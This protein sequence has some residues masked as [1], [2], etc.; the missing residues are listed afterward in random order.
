MDCRTCGQEVDQVL[1]ACRRC[2]TPAGQPAVRPDVPVYDLVGV[3]RLAT[4]AVVVATASFVAF[5]VGALAA[6][7]VG[8]FV[9][10]VGDVTLAPVAHLAVWVLLGLSATTL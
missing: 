7:T 5:G 2:L 8:V 4:V 6:T 3:G 10:P 1:R 9:A